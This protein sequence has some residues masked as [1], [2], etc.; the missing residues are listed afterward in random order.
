M[1]FFGEIWALTTSGKFLVFEWHTVTV[2]SFHLSSSET[3]VPTIL[4]RPLVSMENA[5][6]NISLFTSF[7]Y[8]QSDYLQLFSLSHLFVQLTISVD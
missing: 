6:K 8:S 7:V 1:S 2:A 3:G 5:H 4:L